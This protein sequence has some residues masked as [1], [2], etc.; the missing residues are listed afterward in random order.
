MLPRFPLSFL[1][2]TAGALGSPMYDMVLPPMST[3]VDVINLPIFDPRP[4][5]AEIRKIQLKY[6]N[7]PNVMAGQN[8]VPL[9][10]ALSDPA[11]D[12]QSD[13]AF[14]DTMSDLSGFALSGS[15]PTSQQA[16]M[17]FS[18][19]TSAAQSATDPL[20]DEMQ[21]NLD[22][23]YYGPLWF[24]KKAQEL[25]VIIDTG[26]A[27]LWIPVLCDN[28]VNPQYKAAES[29][30]YRDTKDKFEVT[31]GVGDVQ[32][33]LA[34]DTISLGGLKVNKQYFGAV[35]HVSSDFNDDPISGLLGLGFSSIATS[36][37]P[38]F[39]ENLI[40]QRKVAVPFFSVHLTRGKASGSEITLGGYDM[41]KGVGPLTW[42]SVISKT[43]WTVHFDGVVVDGNYVSGDLSAAIDTGTTLIYVPQMFASSIY[44]RI[45]GAGPAANYGSGFFSFPCN[46]TLTI[47]FSLGGH[48]FELSIRDFNLGQ[49]E[50]RS[51]NCIGGIV[52]IDDEFMNG[53]AIIG[54][55]FLKSWYSV[56]DYSHGARVGFAPSINNAQ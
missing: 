5:L 21:G 53:F 46:A 24:G 8:L 41:S 11:L 18:V 38:T 26:S 3:V 17:S 55:E 2:L 36:G 7:A 9:P 28:C 29:S 1:F 40:I 25:L 16:N 49:D 56:Y 6:R 37:K 27:D 50:D 39:F 45:P 31:Y 33:T 32:G 30:T 35:T 34:Y 4:V 23:Q 42:V 14:T 19:M 44:A 51:G 52:G 12:A 10:D 43:Y 15:T 47:S 54:D 48:D 22:I 20:T 13:A